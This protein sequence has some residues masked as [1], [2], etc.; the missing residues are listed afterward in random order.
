MLHNLQI[1]QRPQ[2]HDLF[3]IDIDLGITVTSDGTVGMNFFVTRI[4]LAVIESGMHD[5]LEALDALPKMKYRNA[6]PCA[7]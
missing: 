6:S 2:S 4:R 1:I 5:Y 3:F 7:G